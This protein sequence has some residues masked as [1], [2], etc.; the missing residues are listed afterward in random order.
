[1]IF[2]G[3]EKLCFSCVIKNIGGVLTIK[4]K[5]L[6][7]GI[8]LSIVFLIG[9]SAEES[10]KK[11][12]TQIGNQCCVDL[13]GN[14]VCD[15]EEAE[16][17]VV[18]E[19]VVEKPVITVESP[20]IEEQTKIQEKVKNET[21]EITAQVIAEEPIEEESVIIEKPTSESY[22][23]IELYEKGNYGYQYIYNTEWHRIKSNNIKIELGMPKKYTPIK[24][25]EKTYPIFYV[26]TVY[27]DRNK[28]EA[29]GYCEK[30]TTCFSED[31]LDIALTMDY[32]NYKEKTSDEWMY[33]YG[34]KKPILFEERK[35]YIKSRLT[36]RAIYETEKGEVRVYYD[37]QIGLVLR[38]EEQIG[39]YPMKITEYLELTAGTVRDIDVKHRNRDEIPPEEVF[40]STRS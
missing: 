21:N 26:D 35:Y 5:I 40:Y 1:M 20:V 12:M 18:E 6:L 28:Q 25:Q 9:C 33:E 23:F 31:I 10:C 4:N 27:L 34:P 29:T 17:T 36:T 22:Q 24:I 32:N 14:S 13:D 39:E 15:T 30:E 19:I 38:V 37:P 7:F 16:E 11:P 2:L 3:A 8:L